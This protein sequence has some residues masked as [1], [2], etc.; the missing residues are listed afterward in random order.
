MPFKFKDLIITVVPRGQSEI[1]ASGGCGGCSDA[2]SASVGSCTHECGVQC[3]DSGEAIEIGPYKFIDPP[4]QLELRQLLVYALAK[5]NVKVPVHKDINVL[6]EQ[7][8]PQSLEEIEA[9]EKQLTG[10]LQELQ[11]QKSMFP[12][13]KNGC[14]LGAWKR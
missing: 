3:F 6:E 10:A 14:L 2:G 12:S 11:Q 1:A 7:M 8:R 4:Y 5:G 13:K 9:L